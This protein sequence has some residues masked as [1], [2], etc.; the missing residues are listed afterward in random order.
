MVFIGIQKEF[1]LINEDQYNTIGQFWDEMAELYGL[2][3]LQ[4]LGFKW[5]NNKISYAIGLKNGIIKEHN[6]LINLPDDNWVLVHGRTDDL[7]EIYDN[8][9]KDGS[10]KYEIETFDENGDC[11]IMYYK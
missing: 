1:S 9:Y 7:K 6:L 10:L 8:I 2:E 5:E 3:N 11:H 4:G